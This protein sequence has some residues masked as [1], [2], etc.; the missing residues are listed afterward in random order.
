[1]THITIIGGYGH[2]G[3]KIARRL[4]AK[5]GL[6]PRLAG[7]DLTRARA[8][9]AE[10]PGAEAAHLDLARP[11]SWD[12][13][14][15]GTQ[16]VVA[17]LDMP[18]DRF[19]RALLSRGLGYAD[20]SAT[21]AVLRRIEGLDAL[22]RRSGALAVLSLGLAPGLTNLMAAEAVRRLDRVDS[23]GIGVLLGLGDSHGT[24]AIDWTLDTLRP[25]APGDIRRLDF[26]SGS[27]PTIPFDFAD[28]HALTRAGLPGVTTR[29]GL[30][31]PLVTPLSLR[32]LA[33]MAQRPRL[34]ALLRW[35]L[36]KI[37][38]GSDRTGLVVT[39]E[40]WRDG[41]PARERLTLDGRGEA[42]IT[43]L[44]AAEM[45]ARMAARPETGVHHLQALWRLDD[46]A[47]ALT[48]EGIRLA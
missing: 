19:A 31:S 39:A 44:V 28:Q 9:A 6:T 33:A 42:E 29:L 48:A 47:P 7:R 25:L 11:E 23:V 38:V 24:A 22:A 2:V 12:A 20:I 40:G 41:R 10:I 43:A 46:L 27:V 5:P 18:D 13:A 34:K 37:R 32:L 30:G 45:L 15:A 3:K 17:C 36:P 26:A 4:A 35:S 8:A 16:I 21:D 1:M 14:L